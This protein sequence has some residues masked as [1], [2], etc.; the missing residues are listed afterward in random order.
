MVVLASP[1]SNSMERFLINPC[2]RGHHYF[3]KNRSEF[4][5]PISD[6][7][8]TTLAFSSSNT[9]GIK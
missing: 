6:A 2:V 4:V 3:L 7:R 8:F 1:V 9:L 5:T